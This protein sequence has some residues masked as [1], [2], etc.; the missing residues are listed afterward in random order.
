MS[1]S[2]KHIFVETNSKVKYTIDNSLE[3]FKKIAVPKFE[4]VCKN[5]RN[6]DF[7]LLI[8]DK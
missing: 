2:K 5:F 4:K 7:S 3:A 8:N 6:T 1:N